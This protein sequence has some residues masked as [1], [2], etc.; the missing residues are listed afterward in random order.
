MSKLGSW[1]KKAV[2]TFIDSD[3]ESD[4]R[5]LVQA[6]E[7]GLQAQRQ[8]FS[9][10]Q[11][12]TNWQYTEQNLN[13][14]KERVYRAAL[15]RGWSDGVLTLGEQQTA[16]WLA[17]RLEL[18]PDK[19]RQFDFEQARKWFGLALA[20]AME[21]GIL[22]EEEERRLQSIASAV[23]CDLPRFARAFFQWEGEAFLRSIFLAC[24]AD[25]HISQQD[26][27]YLLYVTQRFGL[28][29]EEMLATVQPQARQFVEHVLADAKS[30]GKISAHEQQT[31][32]WL[33]TNLHMPPDVCR[34]VTTEIELVETLADVEAGRLPSVALP[35]GMEYR[36]GEI[37][38]WVGHVTWREHKLRKG[39]LAQNDYHGMLALTDNRLIFGGELKSQSFG[40]RKIVAHRGA[41]N[42]LEI[43]LE[44][45]PVNRFFFRQPSPLPYAIFSAAVAMAN[46]TKVAKV[47]GVHSRHIPREVRQRVWQRYG[48]KCAEC[49]ATD[50][51]EFD[52]IIPVARGGSNTDSNIQLLC[53]RCNLKKSDNI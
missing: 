8:H 18:P 26:W 4:V 35:S 32:Q 7:Q 17:S 44:G 3:R 51:L 30:D 11:L 43:Q 36:S 40:Y 25:N 23:G 45:K 10:R 46:Q 22:D 28:T 50:Y 53:R 14:A 29:H 19:Q 27:D 31:L 41:E 5:L 38:H 52:H 37:V 33:L 47:E 21:D 39:G 42:W 15:E 34:Y 49:T 6:I 48:G 13:D 12:L 16:K 20:Q 1:F 24:V 2:T 9:L